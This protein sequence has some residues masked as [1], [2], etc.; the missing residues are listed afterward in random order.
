MNWWE[1]P[2]YHGLSAE[3]KIAALSEHCKQIERER[4]IAIQQVAF[5]KDCVRDICIKAV[6]LGQSRDEIEYQTFKIANKATFAGAG[7]DLPHR[8]PEDPT[9]SGPGTSSEGAA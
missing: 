7:A 8:H 9:A 4:D 5:L 1:T 6:N 3:N 2:E